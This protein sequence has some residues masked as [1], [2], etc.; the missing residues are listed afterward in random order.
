MKHLLI[1]C[2]F[3]LFS[4]LTYAQK[5]ND[6]MVSGQLNNVEN[7]TVITLMQQMG[8]LGISVLMTRFVM[9]ASR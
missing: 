5:G 8:N 1:I 9:V 4:L 6:F 2:L 3:A 7:G